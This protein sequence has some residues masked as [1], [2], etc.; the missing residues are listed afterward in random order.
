LARKDLKVFHVFRSID[1][2][3]Y[4]YM[5]DRL[6]IFR[7]KPKHVILRE[8]EPFPDLENIPY[9]M[10]GVNYSDTSNYIPFKTKKELVDYELPSDFD[11]FEETQKIYPYKR[12][13]EE[14]ERPVIHSHLEN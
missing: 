2:T 10:D 14:K 8:N 4:A 3:K 13:G 11:Y 12:Q 7:G 9:Y 6:H 5:K 1:A